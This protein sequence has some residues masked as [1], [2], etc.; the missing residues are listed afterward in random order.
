MCDYGNWRLRWNGD[1]NARND[2]EIEVEIVDFGVE[3]G[4]ANERNL[5]NAK[6]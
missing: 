5:N 6:F 3:I 4:H 2:I 1:R